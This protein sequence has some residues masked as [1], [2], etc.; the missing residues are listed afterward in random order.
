MT[1]VLAVGIFVLGASV[2]ALDVSVVFMTRS[3]D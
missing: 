2:G 3:E 1:I